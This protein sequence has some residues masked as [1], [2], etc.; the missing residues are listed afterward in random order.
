MQSLRTAKSRPVMRVSDY[1]YWCC[2]LL[3]IFYRPTTGNGTLEEDNKSSTCCSNSTN[4]SDHHLS[5]SETDLTNG[6][7]SGEI[8]GSDLYAQNGCRSLSEQYVD[9]DHM[10]LYNTS[11]NER[12]PIPE[13]TDEEV[14][15][16]ERRRIDSVTHQT[17]CTKPSLRE[18]IVSFQDSG[19][20]GKTDKGDDDDADKPTRKQTIDV[21]DQVDA[22]DEEEDDEGIASSGSSTCSAELI[23]GSTSP[24]SPTSTTSTDPNSN[25]PFSSRLRLQTYRSKKHLH[26]QQQL[27][28]T[29]FKSS[30]RIESNSSSQTTAA[31][32]LE[33]KSSSTTTKVAS[34]GLKVNGTGTTITDSTLSSSNSSITTSNST[35]VSTTPTIRLLTTKLSTP[36]S[37]SSNNN[38]SSISVSSGKQKQP[39]QHFSISS[40]TADHPGS[41]QSTQGT[42]VGKLS[43]HPYLCRLRAGNSVMGEASC[44][45]KRYPKYGELTGNGNSCTTAGS[46]TPKTAATVNFIEPNRIP[47]IQRV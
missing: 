9:A 14:E 36:N 47:D 17:V 15:N 41:F 26:Q 25:N 11:T 18:S 20:G 29:P 16:D 31:E 37:S 1:V 46:A 6:G 19:G 23:P 43:S 45:E 30:I 21:V 13:E 12:I 2:F 3:T 24:S 7:G 32:S 40:A 35:T 34:A 22:E 33:T 38:S 28:L 27:K 42:S 10:R 44:F 8:G 4:G 39:Q 5:S